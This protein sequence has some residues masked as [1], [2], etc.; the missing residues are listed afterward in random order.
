[1]PIT[2]SILIVMNEKITN[3]PAVPTYGPSNLRDLRP[4]EVKR[5][6]TCGL[7]KTQP[8]CDN[9]HIGTAFK[10]L[11]WKVPEAGQTQFSICNCKYTSDPPYCDGSHNNL[12][13]KYLKQIQDCVK[14]HDIEDLKLCQCGYAKQLH[15]N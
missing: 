9:S 13:L 15:K 8:W 5:W 7:S 1:M 12:P 2:E 6:C 11:I 10:P 14:D 4:G 3:K